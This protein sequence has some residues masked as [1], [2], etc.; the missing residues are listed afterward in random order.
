M[1][2][3]DITSF[4]HSYRGKKENKNAVHSTKGEGHEYTY[5]PT[6]KDERDARKR[7]FDRFKQMKES[8]L[9]KEAERRWNLGDKMYRMWAPERHPDDWQADIVL[10]DGF[11]AV[12]THMQETIS[13]RP[14]PSL[15]GVESSDE[16]LEHYVNTVYQYAMDKTDFDIESYK[17]R[18]TSAIR[19]DAFTL[20]EYRYEKREVQDVID[21]D[22]ETNELKYKKREICDYDDVYTR[23]IDNFDAFVDEVEDPK[24]AKDCIW[25][26]VLDWDDFQAEYKD[27]AGFMNVDQVVP[28]ASIHKNAGYF[29]K[30]DDMEGNDVE[31]LH[32]WNKLTDSYDILANNVVIRKGPMPSRHKELPIDKWTFYPIPGQQWGMGIPFIIYTIVEERRSGRNMALD[33]NKMQG[34]KMFLVNDL[35]ELDEDDLTPRPHGMIK[36]NTNGLPIQQAIQALEYGDVPASAIRMDDTLLMEERRAHGLDDRPAQTAGGTATESAIMSEAAQKRINQI[37]TLQNWTTLKSIG[38]KKWS[39]IQLFY[40]SGRMEEV[41]VQNQWKKKKVYKTIKV[42]G[43]EFQI[44]GD[45]EKGE[46]S[47]LIMMPFEGASR[48]KL[49]GTYARFLE[50]NYDIT[51]NA[52]SSVIESAAV[53]FGKV[54]ELVMG[55]SANPMYARYIDG[56]KT[57]R[58]LFQLANLLPKDWMTGAE[59][60]IEDMK[61]LAELENGIIARMA[62]TG[63]IYQLPGTPGAT[64]PHTELHLRFSET[65]AFQELP[66]EVKQVMTNH[67]MMEHDANPNTGGI[68]DKMNQMGAPGTDP[69][70]ATTDPMAPAG[71]EGLPPGSEGGPPVPA[72]DSGAATANGG[73]VTN[74][75]VY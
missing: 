2:N 70:D 1:S 67:I 14:R 63:K 8:P 47:K 66:E 15:E 32:Y 64:E 18:N 57:V 9:R 10:P 48:L 35:F 19:G 38:R 60:N 73:D 55:I 6:G 11:A 71:P 21:V 50:G 68:A 29:Q 26:Q 24:Y 39:N 25:R 37:N 17:A 46:E 65:A 61:N 7:I 31:V 62:Q 45:T 5:K 16:T 69:A 13:L 44:K 27:K 72:M 42:D 36:V 30:S 4:E 51:V 20:E 58:G 54:S 75:N 43:K 22:D 52:N 74:G 34:A 23:W 53:K 56:E 12:Q 3:Q 33:R 59:M 40:P 41:M 28:A 49:D